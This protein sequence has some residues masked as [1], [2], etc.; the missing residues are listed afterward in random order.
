MQ[1]ILLRRPGRAGGWVVRKGWEEGHSLH[2]GDA[3]LMVERISRG[4]WPAAPRVAGALV[5]AVARSKAE[6]TES[7]AE[8]LSSPGQLFGLQGRALQLD[9]ISIS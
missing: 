1:Q 6:V 2:L 4:P 8:A 7:I 9:F 3:G 5:A